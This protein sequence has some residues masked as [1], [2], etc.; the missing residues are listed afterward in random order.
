MRYAVLIILLA[1][2]ACSADDATRRVRVALALATPIPATSPTPRPACRCETTGECACNP[3]LC[4]CCTRGV[5]T[6]EAAK[7]R[8]MSQR[9]PVVIWVGTKVSHCCDGALSVTS[10][11]SDRDAPHIEV[12]FPMEGSLYVVATL[13]ATA[14]RAEIKSAVDRA[15]AQKAERDPVKA[16]LNW[17]L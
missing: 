3:L 2:A 16:A 17:H 4:K 15:A 14:S 12:A 5:P 1:A 11:A 10:P 9:K 13:P 6:L 7:P 8:I